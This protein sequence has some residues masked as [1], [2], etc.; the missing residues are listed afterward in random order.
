MRAL[1]A[2]MLLAV[3][4]CSATEQEHASSPGAQA[5][6]DRIAAAHSELAR[7]TIHAIPRG[8]SKMR[9]VAASVP[10]K[11]GKPS[12]PEDLEA[13]KTGRPVELRE[14]RDLDYT[15]PAQDATGHTLAVIGVLI[16]GA[17][18]ATDEALRAKAK[19]IAAETAAAIRDS[20]QPLW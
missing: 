1:V 4:A 12:D 10:G 18:G 8:E 5:I 20:K 17:S 15:C 16:S 13:A 6:V 9:I 2:L 3:L 19:A 11:V 14:G 7:L